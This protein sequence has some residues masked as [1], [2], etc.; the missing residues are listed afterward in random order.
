MFTCRKKG[1]EYRGKDAVELQRANGSPKRLAFFTLEENLPVWG[2]EAVY[3]NGKIVGHLR[4]GEYGYFLQKP[5]GLAYLKH[6][7]NKAIDEE[8]ITSGKYEIEVMGK[9]Y[10]ASVHL[11]SPFDPESKRFK[12]DY[13]E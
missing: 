13:D 10:N 12:G 6:P 5:I 2:L 7:E 9:L 4:R 3:Q 1:G 11:R 8:F